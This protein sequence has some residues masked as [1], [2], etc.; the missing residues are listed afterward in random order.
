MNDHVYF[1]DPPAAPPSYLRFRN[2]LPGIIMA[3]SMLVG[4]FALALWYDS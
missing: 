3:A 4:A 2:W 1:D